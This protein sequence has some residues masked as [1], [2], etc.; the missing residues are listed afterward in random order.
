MIKEYLDH[1]TDELT[2]VGP[3]YQGDQNFSDPVIF[4]D[5]GT[6]FKNDQGISVGDNDSYD[7]ELDQI[8]PMQKDY[9]DLSYVL[10]SLPNKYR[11]IHLLGF[12]GGR[13][14]HELMN[15]GEVNHFLE[16]KQLIR[17]EFD[18]L[19][20]ALSPGT[21]SMDLEGK[22]SLFS[23]SDNLLYLSG[24]CEYTLDNQTLKAHSSHGLSNR[25]TGLVNIQNSKPL[26]IFR[27][28]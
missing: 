20:T 5:G 2:L 7:G 28:E 15:I 6:H 1:Y 12:M 11:L 22:F 8:L 9:S 17:V 10:K 23:F 26:F 16:Q 27:E 4:V 14:D 24:N 13:K 3:L 21:W 25:G 19:I 18:K